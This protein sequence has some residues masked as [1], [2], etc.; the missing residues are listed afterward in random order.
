MDQGTIE[1][2]YA[3]FVD[4]LRQGG[5]E[6]P[7]DG[8]P[9]EF[10]AA[11]VLRNNDL[12]S[13]VA[14]RVVARG[15]PAYDNSAAVEEAELRALAEGAGGLFGLAAAVETSSRRLASAFGALDEENGAYLVPTIIIDSGQ[16]V[17]DKPV[18]VRSLIEGNASFHLDMHFE[19]LKALH[20]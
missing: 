18:A 10:V 6:T 11:H 16:V 20:R 5:F 19:Q 1:N 8:W 14:E 4:A 12:I 3:P 13:E 2:A 17:R 15:R 9:A 7:A